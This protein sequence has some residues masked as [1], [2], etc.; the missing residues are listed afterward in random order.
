[1][2]FIHRRKYDKY[3]R[4]KA[5]G[6]STIAWDFFGNSIGYVIVRCSDSDNYCK[7]AGRILCQRST[8]T[9]SING[10]I[11]INAFIEFAKDMGCYMPNFDYDQLEIDN[12]PSSFIESYLRHNL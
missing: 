1:M 11:I 5:R 3:K 8:N 2:N 9:S 7:A 12:I 6:G 4:L 10:T